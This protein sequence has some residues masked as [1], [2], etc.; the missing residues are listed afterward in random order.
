MLGALAAKWA[1]LEVGMKTRGLRLQGNTQAEAAQDYEGL[2]T[3]PSNLES[4]LYVLLQRS[5]PSQP[6]HEA[7]ANT[8][9]QRGSWSRN[10]RDLS[11][12]ACRDATLSVALDRQ[13]MGTGRQQDLPSRVRGVLPRGLPRIGKT[14][15]HASIREACGQDQRPPIADVINVARDKVIGNPE[16]GRVRQREDVDKIIGRSEGEDESGIN[17]VIKP[18][19]V[20]TRRSR[21]SPSRVEVG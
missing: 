21:R 17:P 20:Q 15:R 18:A 12:E 9:E 8:T 3:A 7:N 1:E 2:L 10:G 6:T 19:R 11:V 14:S 4:F 5:V 16:V 13:T